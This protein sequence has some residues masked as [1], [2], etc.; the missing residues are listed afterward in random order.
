MAHVVI[1][2]GGLLLYSLPNKMFL[3]FF[4]DLCNSAVANA[5]V[6]S[7]AN[8]VGQGYVGCKDG[9]EGQQTG[10]ADGVAHG[11]A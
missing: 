9:I 11:V 3:I 1:F 8:E 10:I 2:S 6:S 4:A 7:Q 5:Y